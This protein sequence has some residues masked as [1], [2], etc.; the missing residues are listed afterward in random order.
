M[1]VLFDKLFVLL[2]IMMMGG[3]V[4]MVIVR[5]IDYFDCEK[6]CVYW[7]GCNVFRFLLMK[8]LVWGKLMDVCLID[9]VVD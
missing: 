6:W 3:I 4:G 2:V 7:W 5:V 1:I 8:V 9:F